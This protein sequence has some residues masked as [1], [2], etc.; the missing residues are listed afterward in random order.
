MKRSRAPSVLALHK[1]P[2]TTTASAAATSVVGDDENQHPLPLVDETTLSTSALQPTHAHNIDSNNAPMTEDSTNHPPSA[3][4]IAA[5]ITSTIKKPSLFRSPKPMAGKMPSA[6]SARVVACS[7]SPTT[8]AAAASAA[9][10]DELPTR[11]Y[12]VY[13]CKKSNKKHK[14]YDDGMYH[15]H[16]SDV[17]LVDSLGGCRNPS[18]SWQSMHIV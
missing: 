14:S 8:T 11:I 1:R 6:S 9:A 17:R 7:S 3:T 4:P 18:Y 15:K 13:W 12:E 5:S 16:M 2:R 10:A